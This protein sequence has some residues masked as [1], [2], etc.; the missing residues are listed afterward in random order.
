MKKS[1]LLSFALPVILLAGC[2]NIKDVKA[3][4]GPL[5]SHIKGEAKT[6]KVYWHTDEDGTN[7]VKVKN[8]KFNITIPSRTSKVSVK[9]ADDKSLKDAETVTVPK[10]KKLADYASFVSDFESY[11]SRYDENTD[12]SLTSAPDKLDGLEE[13]GSSND[14]PDKGIK[15]RAT[16]D[17]DVLTGLTINLF[18]DDDKSTSSM[19]VAAIASAAD[20]L[21]SSSSKVLKGVSTAAN[22]NQKIKVVSNGYVYDFEPIKGIMI[23]CTIYKK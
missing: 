21:G 9:V 14:S 20:T 17:G 16:T 12:I 10:S 19:F 18:V 6:E 13:I 15:I 1:I 5:V 22:K 2:S 23:S 7:S 11:Y 3:E 8:D 4:N